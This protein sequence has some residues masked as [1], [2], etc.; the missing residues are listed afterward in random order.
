LLLLSSSPKI[1]KIQPTNATNKIKMSE[2]KENNKNIRPLDDG[3]ENNSNKRLKTS[4]HPPA[5]V[6]LTFSATH[7]RFARLQ[8]LGSHTLYHLVSALCKYTPVGYEGTM[9]HKLLCSMSAHVVTSRVQSHI[10]SHIIIF[11]HRLR[12]TK[13]PLMARDYGR[14]H[15]VFV[16]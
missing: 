13:R 14:R 7:D 8:L 5:P 3:E 1:I 11:L 2:P 10:L 12:G 9:G 15:Q 4:D 6:V 16:F